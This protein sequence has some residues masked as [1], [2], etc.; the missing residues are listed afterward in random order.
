MAKKKPNGYW[1]EERIVEEVTKVM[2]EHSEE[3]LPSREWFRERDYKTLGGAI[4]RFGFPKLRELL[5]GTQLRNPDGYWTQERI[6]EEAKRVM[7]EHDEEELPSHKWF[8]R[9]GYRK[10]GGVIRRFG[11][12]KLRK[13]LGGRMLVKPKG[14]WTEETVRE[15]AENIMRDN[16]L[17]E[18]P[19]VKWLKEKGYGY[20]VGPIGRTYGVRKLREILG[21]ENDKKPSGYW[22]EERIVDEVRW[23]ME[24]F[25]YEKLP[26]SQDFRKD[27]RIKY[28]QGP[29]GRLGMSRLHEIFGGEPLKKPDGY[30]IRERVIETC[31]KIKRENGFPEFPKAEWLR[32]NGYS[33]LPTY[34][35]K[36]IGGMDDLRIIL[37]EDA[38][39]LEKLIETNPAARSVAELAV[40]FPQYQQQ[41]LDALQ[42]RYTA[43]SFRRTNLADYLGDFQ[44]QVNGSIFPTLAH[45][46]ELIDFEKLDLE[47]L[48]YMIAKNNYQREFNTNPD[49]CLGKIEEDKRQYPQLETV[50]QR[51]HDYYRE[52]LELEIPG[53]D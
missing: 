52:V 9:K 37:G 8:D 45:Y 17:K 31:R 7:E 11:F 50:L 49:R 46:A 14:Y 16:D 43:T 21:G 27:E 42:K 2:E 44:P 10:L 6:V 38:V 53:V 33:A 15:E 3:V 48:F 28:L 40:T 12:P 26:S 4:K 32:K 41:F 18:L 19:T 30:W 51:T 35:K 34:I 22:T 47:E 36:V 5:G 23:A 13:L 25:G 20:L 39:N 29:V 24:E 1:T